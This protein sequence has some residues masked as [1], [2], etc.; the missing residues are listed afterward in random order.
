VN[1]KRIYRLYRLE[2]LAGRRRRLPRGVPRLAV[3]TCINERRSL[4]FLVD[5]LEDGRRFR[6]LAVVDDFTRTV[7]PEEFEQLTR[8]RATAPILSA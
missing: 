4:D 2:G 6:L 7:P 8:E 1:L 5:V 3:P